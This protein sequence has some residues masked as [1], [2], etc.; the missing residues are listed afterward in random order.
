MIED[1]PYFTE[2]HY[3][4]RDMVR[5]FA[6]E[7]VAPVA[8]EL[9]AKAEFPWEN[10]REMAELGLL[11]MPWAEELGGSG[12][13]LISYLIAINEMGKVDASHSITISAHTTLGTSPIVNFGTEEQKRRYVPL[14]A[15]GR[16]LGGFGLTEE[17]AGSDAGGTRTTA[18]KKGDRWILN[19]AKRFITHGGV[20]EIFVVTA[21]TDAS[22]GTKGITSFIL[23]KE[24][25]DPAKSKAAG[26]G[27]DGAISPMPGFR[28]GKKEDKLGWRASDTCE[29]IFEDVEVPEENV[30]EPVGRGFI[31]FM[32]TLDAGRIGIAA[33]SLGL[34]E[35]AFEE[36]LRYALLALSPG[37]LWAAWHFWRA[38]M[39]V[40]DELARVPAEHGAERSDSSS[41]IAS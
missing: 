41:R 29:L 3:A 12:L 7:K 37:Y 14:L 9:D 27:A 11:G 4:V 19:G 5:Q 17:G 32:Q 21:Q 20:G 8:R 36:S 39:T 24:T 13:D 1:S 23:T 40:M 22:Q 35:G 26:F 6:R 2:Q 31:N 38:S 34:A 33:L 30:L 15:T 10:I 28:A 16:V 25:S 18:V